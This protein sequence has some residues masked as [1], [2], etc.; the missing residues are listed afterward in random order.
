MLY[1]N[2]KQQIVD[3]IAKAPNNQQTWEFLLDIAQIRSGMTAETGKVVLALLAVPPGVSLPISTAECSDCKFNIK[4]PC[5][6]CFC[7]WS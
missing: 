1:M 2:T 4:T 7:D 3:L 6:Q 5:A